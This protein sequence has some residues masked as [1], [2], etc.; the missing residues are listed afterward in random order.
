VHDQGL[1]VEHLIDIEQRCRRTGLTQP[2]ATSF[3][4]LSLV[5]IQSAEQQFILIRHGTENFKRDGVGRKTV[6]GSEP[7]RIRNVAG[8]SL[9]EHLGHFDSPW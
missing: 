7:L 6:T 5:A 4:R 3:H 1:A 9:V 8:R 2:F